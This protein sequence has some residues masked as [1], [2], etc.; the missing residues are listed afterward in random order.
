M[1]GVGTIFTVSYEASPE[2]HIQ[3][4]KA[5][6]NMEWSQQEPSYLY[7]SVVEVGQGTGH[8]EMKQEQ[9][10]VYSFTRPEAKPPRKGTPGSVGF[11]V[12]SAVNTFLPP[13][14]VVV[15]PTGLSFQL[16]DGVEL[17]VRSRSGLASNGVWVAN[18]PGTVD[19]DY[20]GEVKVILYN[21]LDKPFEISEGDRIAQLVPNHVK[22]YEFKEG[23]V[24]NS[25]TRG[26][27]G[28]GSTGVK[29]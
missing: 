13:G 19:P 25:T 4:E 21:S 26:T 10:I 29:D 14:M 18:S 20:R 16:P 5:I 15:V 7:S 12:C 3:V 24:E 28:F 23:V 8:L 17:Q 27:G 22:N 9:P 2:R 6:E 11:D 1:W